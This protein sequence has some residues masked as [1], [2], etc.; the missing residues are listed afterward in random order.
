MYVRN[1][2]AVYIVCYDV[3]IYS[4][5]SDK[6][7]LWSITNCIKLLFNEKKKYETLTFII[8]FLRAFY[9]FDALFCILE[10]LF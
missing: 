3:I 8:F 9:K 1:N 6:N 7:V 10:L 5:S 2:V 4:M